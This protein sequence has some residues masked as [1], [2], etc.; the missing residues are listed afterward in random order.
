MGADF[1]LL[2]NEILL[3][4]LVFF[5]SLLGSLQACIGQTETRRTGSNPE[6]GLGPFQK[7]I[8]KRASRLLRNQKS[9]TPA[10]FSPGRNL[11]SYKLISGGAESKPRLL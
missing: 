11:S 4:N 8:V 7:R 6:N 5:R 1:P 10:A 3:P 9:K 2:S